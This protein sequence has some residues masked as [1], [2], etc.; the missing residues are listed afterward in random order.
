MI[1][2][3]TMV[4]LFAV[5]AQAQCTIEEQSALG[6]PTPGS[7]DLFGSSCSLD[8]DTLAIGV[9]FNL[10][11]ASGRLGSAQVFRRVA[12][13]WL[14]EQEV[15][16]SNGS[17]MD[18]FG[19]SIAIQGDRMIVGARRHMTN[20]LFRAGAAY[21]FR[22]DGTTWVEEQM[23]TAPIPRAD[24]DYGNSVDLDGDIAIVSAPFDLGG[25]VF[26]YRLV[27]SSWELEEELRRTGQE[28]SFGTMA[29]LDGDVIA[30]STPVVDG[31]VSAITIFEQNGADWSLSLDVTSS[32]AGFGIGV[33]ADGD[34]VIASSNNSLRSFERVGPGQWSE[35]GQVVPTIPSL[36]EPYRVALSGNRALVGEPEFFDSFSPGHAQV[37]TRTGTTWSEEVDL[38]ASDGA[39]GDRFGFALAIDGSRAVV[40]ASGVI[41]T[42]P[43]V[44]R[45]GAAYSF[46]LDSAPCLF[47]DFCQGNGGD[48]MGCTD[49]P[50]SNNAAITSRG[51]CLNE[52]NRSG[53]LRASGSPRLSM[54][55]T[56]FVLERANVST[57]AILV[58][59]NSALPA[60][61]S[62]PCFGLDSGIQSA[63]P[64][65]GIRCVG[66]GVVRYSARFTGV[67]G[68]SAS[69]GGST[70]PAGGL[71]ST[72]GFAPGEERFFQVFYRADIAA[73]CM[74]GT[75]T[76]NGVAL[77]VLP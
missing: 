2:E 4:L 41:G 9:P 27:G 55:T 65:D 30:A 50:C 33:A 8:G 7:G 66:E 17:D 68:D 53:R 37:F 62:N 75:N 56:R 72:P 14:F 49:C 6:D 69:W 73:S 21:S 51:G 48:Q 10:T 31:L 67:F 59:G 29:C 35:R 24:A 26:V 3:L 46:D 57:F 76:S 77:T 70:D 40:G 34:W 15:V 32:D 28:D 13:S 44:C 54:D 23:L 43:G 25:A 36:S 39:L 11:A 45:I 71:L 5:G 60:N 42:C 1:R 22:F 52:L 38:I 58:S 64:L 20:G 74:A 12:G 63:A 47:N 18:Q 16:A 19:L 61:P